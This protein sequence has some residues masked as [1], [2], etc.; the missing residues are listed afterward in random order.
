LRGLGQD[1][2]LAG[3]AHAALQGSIKSCGVELRVESSV[4][5]LKHMTRIVELHENRLHRAAPAAVLVLHLNF[6]QI[7]MDLSRQKWAA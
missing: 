1:A 2:N 6:V 3:I 7:D 4:I 5:G